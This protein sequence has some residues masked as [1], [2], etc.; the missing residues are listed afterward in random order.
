MGLSV[1]LGECCCNKNLGFLLYASKGAEEV[2]VI[3]LPCFRNTP[4]VS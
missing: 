4:L 1:L 3:V 2:V